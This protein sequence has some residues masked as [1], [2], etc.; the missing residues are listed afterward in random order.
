MIR[1]SSEVV[2]D[3]PLAFIVALSSLALKSK[4]GDTVH[5]IMYYAGKA[6]ARDLDVELGRAGG[7]EETVGR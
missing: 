1:V 7:L 2:R 6:Q 3:D 5:S 4:W